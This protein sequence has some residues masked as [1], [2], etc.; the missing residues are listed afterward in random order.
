[1]NWRSRSSLALAL[2]ERLLEPVEHRVERD[3]RRGRPR[4]ARRSPSTRW[5]RSPPAIRPAVW[6]MRS[7]GSRPMRTTNHAT[8][9][10][11]SSTPAITRPSTSSSWLSVRS[12]SV[13]GTA[14]T[15][16][17]SP[18]PSERGDER[19]SA[20]RPC[21]RAETVI[22]LPTSSVRGD[23][24]RRP[25]RSGRSR[26]GSGERSPFGAQLARRCR[27]AGRRPGRR[28]AAGR[29]RGR[30]RGRARRARRCPA[31]RA[32]RR[33]RSRPAARSASI[34]AVAGRSAARRR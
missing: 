11:T 32:R 5:E 10:S 20:A 13:S 6:P 15:A 12:T 7:S 31:R 9:A 34:A 24:R 23:L 22:G 8:A 4:C 29:R 14:T 25:R 26:R 17:P 3:A 21:R 33:R 18:R 2:G 19:G 1:M 16:I 27:P 28:R 30:R